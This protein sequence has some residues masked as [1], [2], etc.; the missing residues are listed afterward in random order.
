MP[1]VERGGT[2]LH[3]RQMQGGEVSDRDEGLLATACPRHHVS[4]NDEA[5]A[6]VTSCVLSDVPPDTA[7]EH[8][9]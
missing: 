6:Y 3:A 9:N 8:L 7:D 2:I 5:P 1:A 4:R